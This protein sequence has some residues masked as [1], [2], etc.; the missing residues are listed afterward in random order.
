MDK[1]FT[2]FDRRPWTGQYG[3]DIKPDLPAPAVASLPA[4]ASAA[5][6]R[7]AQQT[8]F[9]TVMPNGMYGSL[10]FREVDEKSDHFARYLRQ[11]A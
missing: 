9:T 10:S 11:V 2:S 6:R 4:M 1:N 5:A 8:A 3:A 7:F